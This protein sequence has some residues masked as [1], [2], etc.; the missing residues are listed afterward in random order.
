MDTQK[1]YILDGSIPSSKLEFDFIKNIP[2]T[3]AQLCEKIMKNA[4]DLEETFFNS[5]KDKYEDIDFAFREES[6][7]LNTLLS[8]Y[9]ELKLQKYKPYWNDNSKVKQIVLD[10]IRKIGPYE[11]GKRILWFHLYNLL[12]ENAANERILHRKKEYLIAAIYEFEKDES[13]NDESNIKLEDLTVSQLLSKL[14]PTP[15]P[16]QLNSLEKTFTGKGTYPDSIDQI[17]YTGTL[18]RL[19]RYL[20]VIRRKIKD[21]RPRIANSISQN[22]LWKATA[23]SSIKELEYENVYRKC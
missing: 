12:I 18:K 13:Q 5:F 6:Y 8:D 1:I 17:I 23:T 22:C 19:W 11:E 15:K 21:S 7:R 4:N 14:F 9:K 20:I 2:F 16:G 10:E 3:E